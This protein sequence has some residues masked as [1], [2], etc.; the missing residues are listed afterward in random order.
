MAEVL[1]PTSSPRELIPTKARL[2]TCLLVI[3]VGIIC[4]AAARWL[5]L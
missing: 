3:Y 2:L 1:V 5:R 4:V